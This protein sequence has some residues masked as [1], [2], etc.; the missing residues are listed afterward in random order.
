VI[1]VI[2]I[3]TQYI[4]PELN[5]LLAVIG[6]LSN[7]TLPGPSLLERLIGAVCI[8]LPLILIV[9]IIPEGFGWGDIKMMAASGVLLGW[10][11]NIAAFFIG[12]VLG[13]IYGIWLLARK[14]KGRKEHF[15][16]GPFLSIGIA[17]SMYAGVGTWLV[18]QYIERIVQMIQL[19]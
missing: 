1:A 19:S 3:D 8:A 16:F 7:W 14:K 2:D 18:S 6:L 15:A 11:G 10:K 17:V 12:L 13:G 9:L 5:I 4:P